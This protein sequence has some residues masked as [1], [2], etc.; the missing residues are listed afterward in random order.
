MKASSDFF[1]YLAQTSLEPIEI[2]VDRAQDAYL[3]A[4]DSDEPVLDFI[5]GICVSN[6]GHAQPAI[7][8]AICDQATAYLHP[9]VYGEVDMSP[10]T[11]YARRLIEVLGLDFNKVYFTPS[12]AEAVEGALKLAKKYTGRSKL[13]SCIGSYHGSTHGALSVSGMEWKKQGYGPF[14]PQV[15]FIPFNDFPALQEI[16]HKTAA[17]I[18]EPIQAAKGVV[19]PDPG[20][21]KAVRKRCDEVGSL[22]ILDEIQTGFGRTGSLFAFQAYGVR[23]DVL[24]LAKALGGGMPLGAFIA[25]DTIMEVLSHDPPLGHIST[26]GGHA[27]CCAAGLAA[28]ELLLEMDLSEIKKKEQCLL[29]HLQHPAIVELR[30]KGLLY[31]M[32]LRD[33]ETARRVQQAALKQGLM[34]IGFLNI[35]NALRISPPLT[36]KEEHLEKGCR[37]LK[38]ILDEQ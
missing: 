5:S 21:L 1:H 10:Q 26:F 23:P 20:Y 2:Q 38:T 15:H 18:I 32:L 3:Y 6:L 37:I 16:D 9:H 28:F 36:I 24:L 31:A 8:Q 17:I 30:G 33:A 14:L 11:R 22:M 34:T 35:E 27:V 4:C 7:I 12:G 25:N 19:L 13:V 29:C